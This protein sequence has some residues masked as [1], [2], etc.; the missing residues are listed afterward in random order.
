ML[1]WLVRHWQ[2]LTRGNDLTNTVILICSCSLGELENA[3]SY[4]E[5]YVE[6]S[7]KAGLQD[8]LAKACSAIGQMSNSLVS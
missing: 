8:Q 4:L 6:V 3:I 1:D 2:D 7:E 5:Q